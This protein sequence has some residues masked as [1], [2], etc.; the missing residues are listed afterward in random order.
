MRKL[1]FA[2][3]VLIVGGLLLGGCAPKEV[4]TESIKIG[5]ITELTG[6]MAAE[7]QT[8]VNGAQLAV[9]EINNAG[10]V[11]IGGKAYKIELLVEDSK[12]DDVTAI[13]AAQKLINEDKVLAI[14][15]ADRGTVANAVAPVAEAAKIV[16]IG[17]SIMSDDFTQDKKYVFRLTYTGSFQG[18]AIANFALAQLGVRNVAVLYDPD[19]ASNRSLAVGFKT[20][21]SEGVKDAIT[22][23]NPEGQSLGYTVQANVTTY[24]GKV[25]A[26]ETYKE[27][28][29]D[30]ATQI[31]NIK[32][33]NPDAIY[34]PNYAF[35]IPAQAQAIRAAGITV[36]LLGGDNW[37]SADL[38]KECGAACEGAYFATDFRPEIPNEVATQFIADYAVAYGA[39][40]EG[41]AALAYEGAQVLK[42][43]LERGGTVE[44]EAVREGMGKVARY[45]GVTGTILFAPGSG[46]PRKLANIMQIK[47]G[48]FVWVANIEQ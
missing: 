10:G 11:S 21:V 13:A 14:I 29:T 39:A 6:D 45:N 23:L 34:L 48:K 16:L 17:P 20:A 15:E 9:D 44:R 46:D 18:K 26:F 22:F 42:L 5:L 37:G 27:G 2:L 7:G 36:P 1:S 4:A 33:A 32:A 35:E 30:Y 25:S 31:A 24:R 40:P 43:A 38:L 12:F 28:A 8:V 3:T 41:F 47:N 19:A